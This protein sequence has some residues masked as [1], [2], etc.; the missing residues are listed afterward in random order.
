MPKER[1]HI[2][3]VYWRD[4]C[5]NTGQH[6][7][8]QKPGAGQISY[9]HLMGKIFSDDY[10]KKYIRILQNEGGPDQDDFT[11]ILKSCVIKITK[12]GKVDI[13]IGD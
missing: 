2:V 1:R 11:D 9:G 4:A 10:G 12:V 5:I 3:A 6:S 8:K 7:L 13:N